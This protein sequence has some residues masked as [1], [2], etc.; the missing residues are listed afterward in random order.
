MMLNFASPLTRQVRFVWT[1]TNLQQ[2]LAVLGS[3]ELKRSECA[4]GQTKADQ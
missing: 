2:A 1:V 4:P 3:V